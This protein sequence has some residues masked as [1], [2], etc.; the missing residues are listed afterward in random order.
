MITDPITEHQLHVN[1]RHFFGKSAT[2]IG[3]AALATL[4][5][6]HGFETRNV[7][8]KSATAFALPLS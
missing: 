2:G 6:R 8:G 3:T 5:G 1:R 7:I 4:L